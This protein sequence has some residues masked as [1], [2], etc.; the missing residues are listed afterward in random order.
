MFYLHEQQIA[1]LAEAVKWICGAGKSVNWMQLKLFTIL[2]AVLLYWSGKMPLK[3]FFSL[4]LSLL[5]HSPNFLHS[6][7][8][9]L[10]I[11]VFLAYFHF[12]LN[13]HCFHLVCFIVH[14]LNSPPFPRVCRIYDGWDGEAEHPGGAC[15]HVSCPYTSNFCSLAFRVPFTETQE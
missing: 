12:P 3:W 5:D 9:L 13:S 1:L 2:M 7:P 8:F 6:V 14:L 4:S 15:P 10:I 11:P